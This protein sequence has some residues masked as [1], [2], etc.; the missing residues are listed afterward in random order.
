MKG[1]DNKHVRGWKRFGF[2]PNDPNNW[3]TLVSICAG[4]V[5]ND[6]LMKTEPAKGGT[7]TLFYYGKTFVE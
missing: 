7:G 4:I 1:T 2:D 3:N 5:N 6:Y